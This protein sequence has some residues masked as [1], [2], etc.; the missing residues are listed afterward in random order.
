MIR[1]AKLVTEQNFT[2]YKAPKTQGVPWSSLKRF[3]QN[4]DG[5]VDQWTVSVPKLGRPFALTV[6][7]EQNIFH[8]I[9]EMQELGFGLTVNQV[10]VIAYKI[11]ECSGRQ[12][13]F[14][15]K[16]KIASK[17]WWAS[18]KERY[19]LSLRVPENLSAYRASM[20]NSEIIYDYYSKLN[21]L[22]QKLDLLNKPSQ[23]WNCDE[24]GLSYVVRP[25]KI[26]VVSVGK[27]YVYKRSYAERGETHTVL[28]CVVQMGHG[29]HHS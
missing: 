16:A 15:P 8:Y 21:F 5:N 7:L 4:N 28:G 9:N 17:W 12:N 11:A 19:G 10:R 1:A 3:I 25:H 13:F 18:F 14:N 6:E 26:I 24:T 20:A 29:S 2:I 22:L 23:I 27:R